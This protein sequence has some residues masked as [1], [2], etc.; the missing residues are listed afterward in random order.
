MCDLGLRVVVLYLV[1]CVWYVFCGWYGFL[2][3]VP[4]I[5]LCVGCAVSYVGRAARLYSIAMSLV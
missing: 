5:C 2:G 1:C 4:I 3:G